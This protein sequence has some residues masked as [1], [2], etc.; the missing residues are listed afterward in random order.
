MNRKDLK[1]ILK[2]VER[3]LGDGTLERANELADRV[4]NTHPLGQSVR[5]D[6]VMATL[7]QLA[8]LFS[9]QCRFMNGGWDWKECENTY[10]WLRDRVEMI[11][12]DP[13]ANFKPATGNR[14][15]LLEL[16]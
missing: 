3:P 15:S 2:R 12:A 6:K 8:S 7:E 9:Y 10:N 14:A 1:K 11:E 13:I 4:H 5:G 16:V